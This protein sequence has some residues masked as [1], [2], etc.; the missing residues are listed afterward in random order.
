MSRMSR[1]KGASAEREVFRII[2]DQT[3]IEIKRNLDQYQGSD[4]DAHIHG[5]CIEIKRQE[6]LAISTWWNQVCTVAEKY[7]EI[8]VLIYR[9]NRQEWKCIL[10]FGDGKMYYYSSSAVTLQWTM[11]VRLD[12]VFCSIL[13]EHEALNSLNHD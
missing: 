9:Q 13:S 12:T 10:P 5:Y 4:S 3:G 6:K 7:D 2:Y 8:P 1:N 11:T